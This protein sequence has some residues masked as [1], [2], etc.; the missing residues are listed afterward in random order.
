[1]AATLTLGTPFTVTLANSKIVTVE[2]DT[3]AGYGDVPT[4]L[5]RRISEASADAREA[6]TV[7]F[8]DGSVLVIEP[9]THYESW[10][11]SGEGVQGWL[12]GPG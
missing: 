9:S 1:M 12:V 8:D 3:R 4:L 7:H 5:R 2:P 11:L 10:Q 6:L